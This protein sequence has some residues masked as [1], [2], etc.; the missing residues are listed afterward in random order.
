MDL[1]ITAKQRREV[2]SAKGL[3]WGA[4]IFLIII[5]GGAVWYFI[6]GGRS[7]FQ[8]KAAAATGPGYFTAAASR[9]DLVISASGSGTLVA[10]Q[11]VDLSFSTR[12]IVDQL[13][14]KAGDP[15]KAGDVLA[16]LGNTDALQ[17]AVANDQLQLLQ[18]K[19]ALNTFQQ[20][21]SV[22]LAQ[23][24][25][26]MLTA[27]QNYNDLLTADQRT[28]AQRCSKDENT[29]LKAALDL[30]TTN[31]D[32][33]SRLYTGSDAW[34][35]AKNN[36][37][38]ALANYNYCIA[39]TPDEKTNASASVQVAKVTLQQAQTS[40]NTLVINSGI[41]PNTLALDQAKVNQAET[42]LAQDQKNL[43]GAT[44]TAPVDGVVTFLAA[45]AGTM[46]DTSKFITISDLSRPTVQASIDETD[47]NKFV[48]GSAANVVFDALPDQT[49]SGKVTQVNPQLTTSGQYQVATGTIQLGA[50]AAKALEKF[51]LGLN[52]SVTI[53]YQQAMNAVLVPV[54]A[55]RDLGNNKYGVFVEGQGS[56]L[57]F[58]LVQVGLMDSTRAQI[59]SGLN[60]GDVVSTGIVQTK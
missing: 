5:A 36:Y 16:K 20:N 18:A 8:N 34:I 58:K 28:A 47:L 6:G 48:V 10:S 22:A 53:I 52:S 59:V 50:D 39:Y 31:L 21:G 11:S 35:N 1:N 4:V 44:L 24:Y 42:Q 7:L 55:V 17:A 2:R 13:N 41:D 12:G 49:F 29:K 19:Q 51:P 45:G 37:D 46:V 14:V 33:I 9:G 3:R 15:V 60:V 23:A 38:T 54:Q 43:Q 56:K 57:Q 40:Y 26:S 32:K 27:Q 25:Q 30:A